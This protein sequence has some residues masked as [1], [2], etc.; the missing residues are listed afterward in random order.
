MKL[1]RRIP[2]LLMVAVMMV[3]AVGVAG[4]GNSADGRE[5]PVR[6]AVLVALLNTFTQADIE[7]VKRAADDLGGTVKTFNANFDPNLQINQCNDAVTS[8]RYDAMIL[9]PVTGSSVVPCVKAAIKAGIKVGAMDTVIGPSNSTV[10][11]QVKGVIGQAANTPESLGRIHARA[12]IGACGKKKKCKV[13][14]IIASPD[15]AFSTA[16]LNTV[17]KLLKEHDN[18]EIV[19][20]LP[21]FYDIAKG[22]D[23]AR[24]MLTA[25]PDISVIDTEGD[26]MANGALRVL[27]SLGKAKKIPLIGQGGSVEAIKLVKSGEYYASSIQTPCQNGK[28]VGRAVINAVRG[29]KSK[30]PFVESAN[31]FWGNIG[32]VLTKRNVAK[33]KSDW[34]LVGKAVPKGACPR[35]DL[36]KGQPKK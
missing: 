27:K 34:A 29:K 33:F 9:L 13:G 23:A 21:G 7:G 35:L 16:R 5:K 6:I 32:G 30:T 25:H 3:V 11:P 4:N 22:G 1:K 18:I 26:N 10:R 36:D 12:I 8:R 15:F 24:T 17:K 14:E 20:T 31:F 2:A 19:S 28:K